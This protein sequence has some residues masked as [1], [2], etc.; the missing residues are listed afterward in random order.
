[1]TSDVILVL[2]CG[3]TNVRA[4]AVDCHGKIIAKGVRPNATQPGAEDA[5]WHIWSLDEIFGKFAQCCAEVRKGL[6]GSNYRVAGLT[7]TTFGVDGALLDAQGEMLYPIISWK[8]PRTVSVMNAIRHY[9]EP[10]T[11]QRI[12]GVGHFSFNT[13][14]KLIWIKENRPDLLERAAH[15]LFISS[16]ITHRLTGELSTD[17]T[18]AGTSQMFDLARDRFSTEILD[19]IGIPDSLF[20]PIVNPG[21]VIGTLLAPIAQQLDLPAGLPVISAGHDTQFA[22][23]GSGAAMNQPILSSGTWE[24]LMAR[25]A[26]VDTVAL[27]AFPEST[28]ELDSTAGFY[29]PGLQWLASGVLEWVKDTCWKGVDAS[30]VYAQMIAE[31]E[32][33]PP[34]CDGVKMVPDLLVGA[35]RTGGGVYTG[36]SI[37]SSRGHL[38]RAA[39]EA[40]SD[41][42]A[43]QLHELERL[44][45]F[46]A[47]GLV[48]VGGGSKNP[49]WNQIKAD[50]LQLPVQAIAE[51]EITVLGAALYGFFGLGHFPTPE[52]ASAAVQREYRIYAPRPR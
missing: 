49:L 39:L 8:C 20:P 21:D 22:L 41:K 43:H 34:G 7:V 14:Y 5:G 29:N 50:A 11:L 40:L 30:S 36:L 27:S 46:T 45:G 47:E 13:L 52:A 42:L 32:A 28:C 31:A 35:N 6:D 44:C 4:I 12:S 48:L 3:A 26:K 24:I 37:N 33:V 1:M 18:M 38:Y 15:W 10:A 51:N 25:S 19:T 2:D 16:L 17:R 23:F 9:I